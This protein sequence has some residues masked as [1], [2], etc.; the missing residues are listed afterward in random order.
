MKSLITF[1]L[2]SVRAA[3]IRN[4]CS[5]Q[6]IPISNYIEYALEVAPAIDDTLA[7]FLSMRKKGTSVASLEE[8]SVQKPVFEIPSKGWHFHREEGGYIATCLKMEC[9]AERASNPEFYEDNDGNIRS[10][11]DGRILYPFKPAV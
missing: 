8:F 7:Q 9:D 3:Q 11:K 2:D 5:R 4:E 1:S 10:A 6:R